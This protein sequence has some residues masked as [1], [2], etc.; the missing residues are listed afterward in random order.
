[1]KNY[2]DN[3][4]CVVLKKEDSVFINKDALLLI[5]PHPDDESLSSAGMIQRAIS[6]GANVIVVFITNGDG[7]KIATKRSNLTRKL[8]P[9]IYKD[10]ALLRQNDAIS[11]LLELGVKKDD[12]IFLG[13]P[14][15]GIDQLYMVN[16]KE[17]FTSKTTNEN[18]VCYKNSY[19]YE[20]Q[21]TGENLLNNLSTIIKNFNPTYII[22]PNFKD[23]HKDHS[24]T[25][26]FV[27]KAIGKTNIKAKEFTYLIH[28]PGWPQYNIQ[29]RKKYA[30]I[31]KTIRG[32]YDFLS[33]E[34]TEEE[35][36]K[37]KKALFLHKTQAKLIKP[38][39]HAFTK[40]N[41]I[42]ILE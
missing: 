6:S 18:K 31:P 2:I 42:F 10:F 12:I 28:F 30:E 36:L 40:K 11:A 33:F 14:D 3:D 15:G 38:F 37:K 39:F 21:Y 7:F 32:K 20:D 5:A 23:T 25:S 24:Y 1:M 26:L 34:L 35:I 16:F 17:P 8:S 13:F 4:Y 41:E 22:Y 29:S 19:K 27:K 9:N